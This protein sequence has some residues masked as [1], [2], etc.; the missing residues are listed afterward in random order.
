MERQQVS[1]IIFGVLTALCWATSPVFIRKGLVGLSSSYWGVTVGLGAA[2]CVYLAWLFWS[3]LRSAQNPLSLAPLSPAIKAALLFQ[4][5]AGVAAALGTL[6]RTIAIQLAPVVVA[7]PLAQTS[8]L[9]MLIFASLFLGRH[10]ER[11]TFKLIL[12]A[13]LVVAGSA[14]VILGQNL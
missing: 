9:F 13:L 3:G 12:G 10:L 6:G 2:T 1:G 11:V 7:I 5:L 8:S 14:L 4:A